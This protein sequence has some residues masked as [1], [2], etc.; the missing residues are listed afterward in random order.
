MMRGKEMNEIVIGIAVMAI[1]GL[2]LILVWCISLLINSGSISREDKQFVK[3]IDGKKHY[4][5]R[6]VK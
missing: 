1:V 6:S 3:D 5:R 4:P 2:L